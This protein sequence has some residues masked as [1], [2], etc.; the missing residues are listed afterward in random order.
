[1]HTSKRK[2]PKKISVHVLSHI[3]FLFQQLLICFWF[4]RPQNIFNVMI[5]SGS[6]S[7]FQLTLCEIFPKSFQLI[8]TGNVI[9]CCYFWS[10]TSENRAEPQK[11]C[12]CTTVC[13]KDWIT[14]KKKKIVITVTCWQ[15]ERVDLIKLWVLNQVAACCYHS[16]D[17]VSH[18]KS[19][20]SPCSTSGRPLDSPQTHVCFS[21]LLANVALVPVCCKNQAL[22][23]A[24]K[25]NVT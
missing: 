22:T 23:I 14:T 10:D 2:N 20:M 11:D 19:I 25:T 24:T 6:T 7:A 18:P 8:L 16:P 1:M 21:S 9:F 13:L 4:C 5:V 3:D 12:K 17:Q 15:T